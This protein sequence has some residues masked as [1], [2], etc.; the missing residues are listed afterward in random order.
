M[1]KWTRG[2]SEP[3]VSDLRAICEHTGVQVEWLVTGDGPRDRP[4]PA[5]HDSAALVYRPAAPQL[6]YAFLDQLMQALDAQLAEQNVRVTT[7]KRSTMVVTLYQM[8]RDTHIIDRDSV[9][10]VARLAA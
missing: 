4:V 3:N 9:A 7:T 10:R 8:F 6:D 2:L 1:R 5:V